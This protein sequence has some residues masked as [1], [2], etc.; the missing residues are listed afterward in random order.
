MS[1]VRT[2]HDDL[3][4]QAALY[5]LGVLASE[6]RKAFETHLAGCA[7]CTAEVRSL[8]PTVAAL[9]DAVPQVDPPLDLRNRVL[10][11]ISPSRAA[12][13]VVVREKRPSRVVPWLAAA[14]A[15]VAA[16]GLGLYTV[17]LRGQV[18]LLTAEVREARAR[19]DAAD[20]EIANARLVASQAQTTVQ[21]IAAPDLRRS[22]LAGQPVA[23]G[24]MA[25]A[26][27]S[28]S[29]GLVFTASDLP[30]LPAGR[31]YQLWI[32]TSLTPLSAVSAGVFQPDASGR[33]ETVVATPINVATPVAMAV[34]IEPAGGVPAPTGDKYL[35]GLVSAL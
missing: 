27:W 6:E 29:R 30:P 9:A 22:D 5:V 17:Q 26:F 10:A 7:D 31:T 8:R 18:A 4:E 21:V 24:A 28:R 32:V 35:V 15:L 19:A 1:A 23:P 34:T 3:R 33:A 16:I 20:R 11:S 13:P 25:R 14:A 2:E 12:A